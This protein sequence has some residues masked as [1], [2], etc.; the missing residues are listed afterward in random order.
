V[1]IDSLK[2]F[3]QM[4]AETIKSA[5]TRV[6]PTGFIF[7]GILSLGAGINWPVQKLLLAEWPP[8]SARGFSGLAAA[9]VL[10][11]IA[12]AFRQSLRVPNGAWP[13]L[14]ISA[15]LNIT[16]WV[17]MMGY[18]L[19]I[20]P[21]SEAAII[22]YT[23]PMWTTVLAAPI[24]GERL[25]ALRV[26]AL[27][28]AFAGIVALL[29]GSTPEAN[30]AKLPGYVLALATA[31]TYALGTIFLKRFPV[32]MPPL[33]SASWQLGLGCLP[34]ALLGLLIDRPDITVLTVVGWSALLYTVIVQQSLGYVCWLA[35]L[36]RLPAS[37][38]AIGTMFVPIFGVLASAYAL[39]EPLGPAQIAALVFTVASVVLAVR[40]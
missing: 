35:A 15:L 32:P 9:W 25:T 28:M 36:H 22:A 13:R 19:T 27:L 38:A 24:L 37:V 30:I 33:G 6:A 14:I 21:A 3:P 18:A 8:L 17:I 39:G 7:L 2:R 10:A 4:T 40:A 16:A 20:L 26:I 11:L 5:P 12:V 29:G 1:L 31:V 34:V 23:S